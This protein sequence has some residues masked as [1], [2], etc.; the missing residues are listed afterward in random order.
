LQRGV[1]VG[2]VVFGFVQGDECGDVRGEDGGGVD[3]GRR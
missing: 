3:V 1:Q 2:G